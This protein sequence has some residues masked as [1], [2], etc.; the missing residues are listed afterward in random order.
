MKLFENIKRNCGLK[1]LGK[2][3]TAIK[4]TK[5]VH[6]L[7]TARRVALVTFI[8]NSND[9]DEVIG[10]LSYLNNRHL[11]VS[12]IGFFPGKEIPPK[13]ILRKDTGIFTRNDVNWYGKPR[14]EFVDDF[15]KQDFDILIDLSMEEVFPIRWISS[16]SKAKFKVGNLNYSGNPYDLII[17]VEKSKGV[18]FLI[19][20]IKH[21]L[22][23]LNNRFAQVESE[24]KVPNIH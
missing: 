4:R 3:L 20:Q 23:L 18:S 21:Y 6:N 8:K 13:M 15:C 12:V 22:L 2:S 5:F 1:A 10:F 7:V 16:L 17:D 11:N 9:F 19:E 24:E 14:V